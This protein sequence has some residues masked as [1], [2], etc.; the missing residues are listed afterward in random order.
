MVMHR[1]L[2][3][4][5]LA[6]LFANP[7]FADE[8]GRVGSC[9]TYE[10]DVVMLQG[11]LRR[12]TFPGVPNYESVKAG[13]E[14]ETGFYLHLAR[15]VCTTGASGDDPVNYSAAERSASATQLPRRR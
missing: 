13:D 11:V 4:L 1:S 8:R 3:Q 12:H 2:V 6:F 15:P 7:V 14:P 10:P 5:A 9:L